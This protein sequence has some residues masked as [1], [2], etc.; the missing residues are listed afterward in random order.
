M[1]V[2]SY[3]VYGL[4]LECERE[5]ATGLRPARAGTPVVAV[6][7]GPF[8]EGPPGEVLHESSGRNPRGLPYLSVR[9]PAP[10][11]LFLRHEGD[12]GRAEFEVGAGSVAVR[13]EGVAPRD[14][15]AYLLGPVL[16]CL[17]RLRGRV[18]LHGCVLAAGGAAV[19][20]TGPKGAGKSTLA[21]ALGLPV[22]SDDLAVLGEGGRVE[23][24]Y[25]RVRLWADTVAAV[26]AGGAEFPR[27][28]G[29]F[30]KFM[31]PVERFG[32]EPLPLR[33]VLQLADGPEPCLEEVG[34]A[35][36]VAALMGALYAPYLGP[37]S[38]DLEQAAALARRCRVLR[39]R[40]PV[41][42]ARLLEAA[43]AL[44]DSLTGAA[45]PPSA[46]P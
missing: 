36:G 13:S 17:L 34:E 7:F 9:R 22:L 37:V 32:G 2:A 27:V 11:V 15:E 38:R 46:A 8:A 5:L 29:G 19:A 16:G 39:L 35:R 42:L 31:V 44:A 40:R 24:G 10:E 3:G 20:L 41:G 45:T 6:R 43:P 25:P 33:A 14:L 28:M 30:D 26:A 18:V 1:G 4:R 12:T 21:A 23:P